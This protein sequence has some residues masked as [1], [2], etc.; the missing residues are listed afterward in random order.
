M[1]K[2][3][4]CVAT[5]AHPMMHGKETGL[6]LSEL[7][8]FIH[9]VKEAGYEC[10]IVG[11]KGG[12]ITVDS[13]SIDGSY[14][15]DPINVA[16]L[17]DENMKAQ[18]ENSTPIANVNASD[19]IAIYLAGG[20]GTLWD[21]RQSEELQAKITEFHS[22]GKILSAVCHGPS[23]LIDSKDKNGNLIVKGKNVTGFTNI[24]DRI[25][26]VLSELPYLLEDELKKNGANYHKNIL[27]F[28]SRVEVD[29]KLITGQNPQSAKAVAEKV[30][31]AL[32]K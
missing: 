15:K 21:F 27:P 25:A 14:G 23:G 4:L 12:K 9:V 1:S 6:W 19:Y 16:F 22:Q 3:I 5:N 11:P 17:A 7:T 29:G 2:R 20:H 24:E 10:D 18:L 32:S 26:G 30:V 8:H 13:A 31:E 28:T